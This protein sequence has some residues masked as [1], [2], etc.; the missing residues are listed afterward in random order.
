MVTGGN[1]RNDVIDVGEEYGIARAQGN[2]RPSGWAYR[3][4][5][6]N[7]TILYYWSASLCY[8]EPMDKSNPSTDYA[9]HLDRPAAFL[10]QNIHR[11]DVL[12][13]NT[14]HHWNRGKLNANRCSSY[15]MLISLSA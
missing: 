11:F 12:V 7:T 9:M 3:F 5:S 2:A 15:Y 6:T 8:I 10:V 13:L 1:E 14:R 4:P